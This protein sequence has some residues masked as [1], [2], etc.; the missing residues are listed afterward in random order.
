MGHS[1]G[2]YNAAMLA[3]DPRWIERS[4]RPSTM[5]A[6][7]IG[8]A[9]PYDF[10]PIENPE[11]KPVFFHP[12]SPPDSQPIR[13][14]DPATA[15]L[16]SGGTRRATTGRSRSAIRISS[17]ENCGHRRRPRLPIVIPAWIT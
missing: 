16:V 15:A 6:G 14:A 13:Y 2:A 5:F 8:L 17:P 9:G 12:H 1:A 11:V 3:L 7:F 10:L 4:A